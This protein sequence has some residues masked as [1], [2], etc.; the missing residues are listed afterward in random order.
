[1]PH[2]FESIHSHGGFGEFKHS[3]FFYQGVKGFVKH[4]SANYSRFYISFEKVGGYF[5]FSSVK[6]GLGKKYINA[7]TG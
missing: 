2:V 4:H 7:N 1:M 3:T 6:K 5:S